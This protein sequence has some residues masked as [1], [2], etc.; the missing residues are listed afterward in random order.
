MLEFNELL[1]LI[2]NLKRKTS[3]L[4]PPLVVKQQIATN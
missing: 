4:V 1:L 3:N 2:L